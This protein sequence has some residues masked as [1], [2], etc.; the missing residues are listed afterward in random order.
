MNNYV[1]E[2]VLK[3]AFGLSMGAIWQHMSVEISKLCVSDARRMEVFFCLLERLMLE[4]RVKLAHDGIFFQ[5]T[6]RDQ[7][8]MLRAAWPEDPGEDDLDGFGFWFLT[9]SPAGVV[10]VGLDGKEVW[11]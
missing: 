10:W 4:G 7:I 8:D 1:Y 3:S 2:S 9:K 6:P 5:G 11:T